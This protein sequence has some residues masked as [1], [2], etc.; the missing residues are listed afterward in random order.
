[1]EIQKIKLIKV[2]GNHCA[3][4]F[5]EFSTLKLVYIELPAVYH[6]RVEISLPQHLGRSIRVS[7]LQMIL[8]QS[9]PVLGPVV[10]L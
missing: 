7:A 10:Y 8:Q 3:I 5:L 6:F 4:E 9:L 1:M 2:C